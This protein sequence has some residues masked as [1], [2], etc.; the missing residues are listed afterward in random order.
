[1]ICDESAFCLCT[2]SSPEELLSDVSA[3]DAELLSAELAAEESEDTLLSETA[4]ELPELSFVPHAESR[5]PAE[6]A[7]HKN[8]KLFFIL[9]HPLS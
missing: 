1:M 4:E 6:R 2:V 3:S 7:K 8:F 9:P 5:R